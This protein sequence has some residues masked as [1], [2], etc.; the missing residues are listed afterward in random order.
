M[1]VK[2]DRIEHRIDGKNILEGVGRSTFTM[3][4]CMAHGNDEILLYLME[5]VSHAFLATTAL[6]LARSTTEIDA[7]NFA[8]DAALDSTQLAFIGDAESEPVELAGLKAIAIE[9]VRQIHYEGF[10]AERDDRYEDCSLAAAA[11]YYALPVSENPA[12]DDVDRMDLYPSSWS[13]TLA[14][15]EFLPTAED[16][17]KNLAKAGA[18]IAA[19]IDRRLRAMKPAPAVVEGGPE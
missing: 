16:E 7:A 2:Q 4:E 11:C 19:E 15:R 10:D 6:Q 12:A 8:I 13:P 1:E 18:L 17:L 5:A 14:K 3:L 9:R